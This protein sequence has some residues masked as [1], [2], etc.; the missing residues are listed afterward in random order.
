MTE[1][2]NNWDPRCDLIQQPKQN[3]V[4]VV[5]VLVAD[6]MKAAHLVIGVLVKKIEVVAVV[7]VEGYLMRKQ[8]KWWYPT[9]CDGVE[10][11]HW[12]LP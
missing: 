8:W 3:L 10:R 4:V 11:S 5:V 12:F 2:I 9:V 7:V 1:C 6:E